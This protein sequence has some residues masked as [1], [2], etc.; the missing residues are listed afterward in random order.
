MIG[1]C[2]SK[3]SIPPLGLMGY[4]TKYGKTP[5]KDSTDPLDWADLMEEDVYVCEQQ[6]KSLN[7]PLFEIQHTA[8][9]AEMPVREFQRLV[10]EWLN[11]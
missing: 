3:D 6:Q 9:D 11:N 2:L 10:A 5:D 4:K 7:N 1:L 8:K